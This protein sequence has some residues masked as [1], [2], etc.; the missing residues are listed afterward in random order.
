[1]ASGTLC[2]RS[3]LVLLSD[4]SK[5]FFFFPMVLRRHAA[6]VVGVEVWAMVGTV[7]IDF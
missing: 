3:P 7:P 5:L 4:A 2:V 1:M 6:V